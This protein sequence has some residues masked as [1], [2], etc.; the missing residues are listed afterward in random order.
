MEG[1]GPA[2]RFKDGFGNTV[3]LVAINARHEE[4]A[5]EAGGTVET[6]DR[7]GVVAGLAEAA[8]PRV[9]LRETETTRPDAAIRA[10]AASA[11][12]PGPALAAA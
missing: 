10:L 8:P 9:F 2:L 12:R 7:N 5:I 6:S 4:L 3:D 1:A 11:R